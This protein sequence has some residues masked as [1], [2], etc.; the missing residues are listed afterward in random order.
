[1]S[2]DTLDQQPQSAVSVFLRSA[3]SP[4]HGRKPDLLPEGLRERRSFEPRPGH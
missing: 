1:M 2:K 4:K 3:P